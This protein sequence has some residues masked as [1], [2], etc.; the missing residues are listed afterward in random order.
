MNALRYQPTSTALKG[1]S[2]KSATCSEMIGLFEWTFALSVDVFYYAFQGTSEFYIPS[3]ASIPPVRKPACEGVVHQRISIIPRLPSTRTRCP[4]S[5]FF[6]ASRT[7]TTA[8]MP[9]SRAT[10]EP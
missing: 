5:K 3:R 9:Y 7:P 1:V 8:G 4:V 6:V 2:R 10:T